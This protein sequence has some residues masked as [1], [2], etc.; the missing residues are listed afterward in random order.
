[1]VFSKDKDI[2]I[3]GEEFDPKHTFENGQ[4]FRWEEEEGNYTV[5]AGPYLAKIKKLSPDEMAELI[6]KDPITFGLIKDPNQESLVCIENGGSMEDYQTF[7]HKYLDMDRNYTELR[8]ELAAIDPYMQRAT[9]SAIGL[10]VLRQ[11]FFEMVISFIISANNNI[12]RIK[13][14]IDKLCQLAGEKQISPSGISYYKFPTAEAMSQLDPQLLAKETGVGYRAPYLVK[15]A[16]LI[17][18]KEVDLDYISRLGYKE[19]HKEIMRLSGVGPKVADCILLFGDSR[20]QAFP[21]DTW[22]IKV[23]KE[24]YLAEENTNQKIKEFGQNYFGEKA[25]LAQQYLFYHARTNKI[26]SKK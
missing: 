5:V 10:R 26:G 12:S 18:H 9:E 11:D 20:D 15:T 19:A 13:K 17:L 6:K 2:Y 23:M 1:M 21:V 16:Q 3:L 14:S 4:A 7:W 25:G 8:Q 22:V 24:Y